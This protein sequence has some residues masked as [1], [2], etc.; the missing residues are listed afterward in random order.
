MKFGYPMSVNSRNGIAKMALGQKGPGLCSKDFSD[1]FLP[2]SQVYSTFYTPNS[3]NSSV[4][5]HMQY[6]FTIEW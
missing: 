5:T 3:K 1:R 2:K 4:C 6:K